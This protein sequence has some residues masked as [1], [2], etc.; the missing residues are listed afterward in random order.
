LSDKQIADV[1]G[2]LR[3]REPTAGSLV[4]ELESLSLAAIGERSALGALSASTVGPP[5]LR[6][7]WPNDHTTTAQFSGTREVG[8]DLANP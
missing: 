2:V 7:G 1:P 4:A 5:P 3:P 6:R 8:A